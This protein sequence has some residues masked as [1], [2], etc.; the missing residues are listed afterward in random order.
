MKP[1]GRILAA[2]AAAIAAS[3]AVLVILVDLRSNAVLHHT[4]QVPAATLTVASDSAAIA[5]GRHLALVRG[6]VAC[7]G[8]DLGGAEIMDGFAMGRVFGPNITRG[9]GGLPAD[10]SDEDFERAIRHGIAPGGRGLYLMPSED[11]SDLSRSDL[12]DLIA[13]VKAAAP[14][15]R[16]ST[17]LRLGPVARILLAT[18][19]LKLAAAKINHGAV[20]PADIPVGATVD[21]GRYLSS[22]CSG[23]H[24]SDFAG[25]KIA[26]GPPDWPPS[27]NLT[28]AGQ[29]G[30]WTEA[31]FAAVLRTGTRPDGS[32]LSPVMPLV[33]GKMDPTETQALWLFLRSLPARGDQPASGR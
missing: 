21:Y 28:P 1:L 22:A 33:F 31:E 17:P 2:S 13:Y 11:Y 27:A 7:H 5:R 10:F 32:H 29:L 23:C 3:I 24:H 26:G 15:N 18:G 4:F 25:G 6:C 14:V 8:P 16:E 12:N 19:K 30:G 20:H 9:Q